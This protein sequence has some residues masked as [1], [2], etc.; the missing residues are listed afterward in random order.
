MAPILD[1]LLFFVKQICM[2][3]RAIL[4]VPG[5]GRVGD[6]REALHGFLGIED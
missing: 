5:G 4:R 1:V 6:L 2:K 3:K